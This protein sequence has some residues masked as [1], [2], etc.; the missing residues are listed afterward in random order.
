VGGRAT[1]DPFTLFDSS[2]RKSVALLDQAALENEYARIA[3]S[4]ADLKSEIVALR[5]ELESIAKKDRAKRKALQAKITKK[6][7]SL[8]QETEKKERL[9]AHYENEGERRRLF[10]EYEKI[11]TLAKDFSGLTYDLEDATSRQQMKE[12]MLR[13][14]RPAALQ[15]VESVADSYR[16]KFDRPLPV[17]SLVRPEEYQYELS[18]VNPNATRNAIPPHST[19][20]AFDIFNRYMTAEEQQYVMTEL[21]RLKDEARIEVLRENRDH[22]HVFAFVDGTRPG[23]KLIRE[24]LGKTVVGE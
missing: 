14:L 15:V 22:F 9:E 13:H 5:E 10:N 1:G 16:Q 2:S 19:G 8:K 17:S 6:E 3:G 18:K 21:A 12:R 20:L 7:K 4:S 23:E 11:K 24:S